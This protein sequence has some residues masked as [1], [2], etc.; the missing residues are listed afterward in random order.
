MRP[1]LVAHPWRPTLG[2]GAWV[3]DNALPD[4]RALQRAGV[5]VMLI[6]LALAG[7]GLAMVF[8]SSS[9]L[10]RARYADPEF[11]VERQA[12]RAVIGVVV[13]A[14][15]ACVPTGR[16][17]R[18]ARGV[19]VVGWALLVA[20][21]V[22]GTGRADRSLEILPRIWIQPSELMK[23]GIVV[24]LADALDRRQHAMAEFGRGLLPSLALVGVTVGLIALQPDL[25]T[26]AVVAI[27]GATLIW[28]GGA[29]TKHLALL[30]G[31]AALLGLVASLSCQ[32][33]QMTR[34]SDFL[35]GGNYQVRQALIALGTGGWL[36]VGLGNSVQ[37]L[38]YLPE[39]HTDFVFALV[40]EELGLLGTLSVVGLLAAFVM[41]GLRIARQASTYHAYLLAIGVTAMVATN[42]MLNTGVATGLLPTTGLP[43]PFISYGG[44]SLLVNLAGVGMLI[45]IS[46]DRSL[47]REGGGA[48]EVP[49]PGAAPA[50]RRLW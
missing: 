27:L 12:S 26:S 38:R 30:G 45:G 35:N 16:W 4:R 5:H 28:V 49:G 31:G 47:R 32:S 1:S 41:S 7:L 36:G 8:S 42:A 33:Y 37:K 2:S 10:A 40:G 18:W 22:V 9:A 3:A 23:L 24:Y 21:L 39:P 50:R 43:L 15:V 20:V 13:M 6:A 34:I 44:T 29:R 17:Q 25:S 46:R 11:F 48:A 14:V 19:L